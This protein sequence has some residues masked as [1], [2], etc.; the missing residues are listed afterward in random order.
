MGKHAI[1]QQLLA[2]RKQLATAEAQSLGHSVQQRLIGSECFSRAKTLALYSPVNNEVQT[3]QLLSAALLQGQ[4][5]CYPRVCGDAL[6]FVAVT[7]VESLLPGAFGVAEPQGGSLVPV[8]G[9]DLVVVPGIAFDLA[10]H[11]LGYGKGFYD[12]ELS[13]FEQA[14]VSVGLCYDFQLCAVLPVEGHDQALDYIVTE[15]RLIP[16][17][18]NVAG[19]P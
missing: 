14:A 10:G 11:R 5:V 18:K 4:R 2:R 17:H 8:D 9:I 19:S 12:R 13:R 15:K 3:D 16:C 1:R 7:S 6:K